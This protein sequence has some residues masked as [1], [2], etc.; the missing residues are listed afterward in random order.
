ME[1]ARA[2]FALLVRPG[3]LRAL[4]VG[5]H[6]KGRKSSASGIFDTRGNLGDD[7]A[8]PIDRQLAG[9]S[10]MT[11]RSVVGRDFG[12]DV[13]DALCG[14]PDGAAATAVRL[15]FARIAAAAEASGSLAGLGFGLGFCLGDDL[16]FG[17]DDGIILAAGDSGGDG[18]S[19]LECGK[20]R[21]ERFGL[22][23]LPGA[24]AE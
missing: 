13:Q 16:G 23:V 17:P 22:R 18:L 1:L 7:C 15:H 10:R 3:Y 8:E 5:D 14:L 21:N 12:M 11:L 4:I 6:A 2:V 24:I 9:G 20:P 19:A